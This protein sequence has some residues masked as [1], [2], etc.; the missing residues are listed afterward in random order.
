MAVYQHSSFVHTASKV[1]VHVPFL[2][3]VLQKLQSRSC[4]WFRRRG[5]IV[6]EAFES[7]LV[8]FGI[9]QI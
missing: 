7:I 3:G 5:F 6:F 4:V 1:Y 2:P 8:D 9:E